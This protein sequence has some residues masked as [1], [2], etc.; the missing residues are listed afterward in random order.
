MLARCCCSSGSN[1][2]FAPGSSPATARCSTAYSIRRGVSSREGLRTDS[3]CVGMY[4][5]DGSCEGGLQIAQLVSLATILLCGLILIGAIAQAQGETGQTTQI[6]A[7]RVADAT[8][9]R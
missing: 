6:E 2:A 3:L 4:T 1:G 5:L 9:E 7:A 8:R